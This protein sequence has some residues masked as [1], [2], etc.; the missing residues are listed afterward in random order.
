M[1]TAK[2]IRNN[3]G[4]LTETT[5]AVTSTADAI[6]SLNASGHLDASVLPSGV[7]AATQVITASEALA[8]GDFVNVWNSSGAFR[9]RKADGSTNGKQAH[10]FVLAAVA[11][12][13]AATVYFD[14]L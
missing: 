8:A 4:T 10:G 2:Y 14:D 13:A 1:A 3:A 6:V 11:S 5:A 12:G 9:V 7:G